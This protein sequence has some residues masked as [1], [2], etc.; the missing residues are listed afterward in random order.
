MF[1]IGC[2]QCKS[3]IGLELTDF[4]QQR[5]ERRDCPNCG[6]GLE[7]ANSALFFVLNGLIFGGLMMTLGYRGLQNQ[8]LKVI[9]TAPLCWLLAPVIV[10][11]VGRWRVRSYDA[12]DTV[13]ALRWAR[14]G[15]ISGWVF[16]SAVA[17]AA[18]SLAAHLRELVFDLT[19]SITTGDL[20]A[21][22]GPDAL[23]KLASG[24]KFHVLGGISVAL[25]ALAITI[26]ARLKVKKLKSL[27][28]ELYL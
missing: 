15:C 2:P 28:E 26:I 16:G 21:G 7:L 22:G 8:W 19:D 11:I 12:K 5:I 4:F 24:L 3:L 14:T 27:D 13:N 18:I 17:M 20:G 6:A 10:Q 25:V 23:E 9:I 1:D